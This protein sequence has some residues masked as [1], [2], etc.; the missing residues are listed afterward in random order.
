MFKK[1]INFIGIRTLKT[2]LSVFLSILVSILLKREAPTMGVLAAV[3]SMQ[4]DTQSSIRFGI[5]RT[6]GNLMGAAFALLA[7]LF[8]PLF[9]SDSLAQLILMPLGVM[10]I[11][12]I[13]S[14]FKMQSVIVPA[15]ATFVT[16]FVFSRQ[17]P[18]FTYAFQRV[19]DTLIGSFIALGVNYFILPYKPEN[20]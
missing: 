9:Q 6:A 2:G 15:T 4:V 8:Y 16:I 1:S 17:E 10:T 19:I 18:N 12:I 11:I 7:V 14:R 3:F 5:H 13:F 20:N